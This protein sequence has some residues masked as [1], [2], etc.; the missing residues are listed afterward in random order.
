MS[1]CGRVRCPSAS[2]I[3]ER[4]GYS[5]GYEVGVEDKRRDE[6]RGREDEVEGEERVAGRGNPESWSE[7]CRRS[8]RGRE[9][10]KAAREIVVYEGTREMRERDI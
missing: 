9:L 3:E 4:R 8:S 7:S 5:Q 6:K 1:V 10:R 2:W